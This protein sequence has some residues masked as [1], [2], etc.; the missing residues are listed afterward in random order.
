MSLWRYL[1]VLRTTAACRRLGMILRV[2]QDYVVATGHTGNNT[3]VDWKFVEND[4]HSSCSEVGDRF[5]SSKCEASV[6]ST[7]ANRNSLFVLFYSLIAAALT[8]GSVVSPI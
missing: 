3:Q 1:K 5:S 8:R 6:P 4:T 7:G 2:G